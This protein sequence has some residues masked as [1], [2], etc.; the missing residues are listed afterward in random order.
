MSIKLMTLAWDLPLSP[1]IKLV[2]LALCDWA[3]D[4]GF[5]WPSMVTISRRASI[6]KRQGQRVMGE[7][8]AANLIDVV[9]NE[10]GGRT[11]R[12]YQLNVSALRG[13]DTG[14]TG[15][16]L[17]PVASASSPGVTPKH[18]TDDTDVVRTIT[19]HKDDPPQPHQTSGALDWT[20]LPTLEGEERVVVIDMLRGLD[21]AIRQDILDELA[22]A[23]QAKA[24]KTQWPSWLRAVAQRARLGEFVP[25]HARAIQRDRQRVAREAADADKRKIDAAR[26]DDPA[27]R[28][29][30]LA[31]MA[32]A[33]AALKGTPDP[34]TST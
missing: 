2:L 16:K 5:C 18:K 10:Q 34:D 27:A 26:R 32:V 1:T 23:L 15:A 24:I 4:T 11:S 19:N 20:F 17:S 12:R 29:R 28:R 8:I 33:I 3:N 22:G 7:L 31:A 6:S 13:G 25:S 21:T 9:A 30:G 14:D